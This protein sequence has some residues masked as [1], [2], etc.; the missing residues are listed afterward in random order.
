MLSG[1]Y[2][3]LSENDLGNIY[4]NKISHVKLLYTIVYTWQTALIFD[5]VCDLN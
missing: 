2:N 3:F 5:L 1:T 4:L